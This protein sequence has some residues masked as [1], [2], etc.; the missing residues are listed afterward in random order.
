MSI[1][2]RL[3]GG[4][5]VLSLA[6]LTSLLA[7]SGKFTVAYDSTNIS[8]PYPV[9]DVALTSIRTSPLLLPGP[10]LARLPYLHQVLHRLTRA[11]KQVYA[12]HIHQ[13]RF[14]RVR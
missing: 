1:S 10:L 7:P 14:A 8:Q 9:L 12:T 2:Y 13:V 3:L 4:K 5:A 6:D 11:K